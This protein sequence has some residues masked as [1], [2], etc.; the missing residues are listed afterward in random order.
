MLFVFLKRDMHKF[1]CFTYIWQ[2]FSLLLF[3]YLFLVIDLYT[4]SL[5]GVLFINRVLLLLMYF[6][7]GDLN[8]LEFFDKFTKK[9]LNPSSLL[10]IRTCCNSSKR[11]SL[12]VSLKYVLFSIIYNFRLDLIENI[13]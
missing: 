8:Y 4:V 7:Y 2:S 1:L 3:I 5:L 13:F 10:L 9:L 12:K 6:F 11:V